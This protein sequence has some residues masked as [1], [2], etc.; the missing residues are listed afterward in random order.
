MQS[1]R[2]AGADGVARGVAVIAVRQQSA[3]G[4][5]PQTVHAAGSRQLGVE[6]SGRLI[7]SRLQSQ[8]RARVPSK[9]LPLVGK[10]GCYIGGRRVVEANEEWEWQLV[11]E[12]ERRRIRDFAERGVTHS[13]AVHEVE[14]QR[15][16]RAQPATRQDRKSTRLNSSHDQISYAVFCLKKKKT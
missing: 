7:V 2:R 11:T 15:A 16:A 10:S 1:Q 14:L 5:Q 8:P 12:E 13:E 3:H 6:A 4:H 9:H